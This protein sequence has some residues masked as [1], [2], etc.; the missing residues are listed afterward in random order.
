MPSRSRTR[1]PSTPQGYPGWF[2]P[3]SGGPNS[4]QSTVSSLT[5]SALHLLQPPPAPRMR[6]VPLPNVRGAHVVPRAVTTRESF[7]IDLTSDLDLEHLTRALGNHNIS[8]YSTIHVLP[9]SRDRSLL[10]I[11]SGDMPTTPIS[12]IRRLRS[13]TRAPLSLQ[14]YRSELPPDTQ[15]AV[16]SYFLSRSG[17]NG[18]RLWQ[19]FLNGHRHPRGPTGEDLLQGHVFLWGF[20]QDGHRQWIVDVDVPRLP[21]TH[22]SQ[23]NYSY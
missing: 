8:P 7:P 14:V 3:D 19:D 11:T 6:S 15:Q 16:C 21:V 22:A 9:T 17:S 20:W 10:Q 5:A 4:P 23:V 2:C 13:V 18:R 12:V 1:S